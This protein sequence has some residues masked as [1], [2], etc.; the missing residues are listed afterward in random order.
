MFNLLANDQPFALYQG[1]LRNR[2]H[3]WADVL[4]LAEQ[5]PNRSYVFNFCENRYLFCVC[6]LAALLRKQT[7]LLPPN[8]QTA[9]IDE[10]RQ[11]YPD[12]YLACDDEQLFLNQPDC[13][14][15]KP[16]NTVSDALMPQWNWEDCAVIAFTSGSGG[17]AKPCQHQ[18]KT[19]AISAQLA[20]QSLSLNNQPRLMV[21]TTP[22]QHMYGL[23]TSVFWP[24][25]S[26]LILYDGHP[27]F[28]EDVRQSI[29]NAPYPAILSTTPAHLRSLISTQAKWSN[30]AAIIS[31]TDTLSEQLA[32]QT[33]NTLGML[34]YEIYGSTETLSFAYRHR[35]QHNNWQLYKNCQLHATPNDQTV[36]Q[37]AHLPE[38]YVLQDRIQ[39]LANQQF[40]LLG[41][42]E[43]MIK[44]AGKRISLSE[45]NQR[46]QN[47]TGVEDGVF[48][49]Q[50]NGENNVRLSA[51]V[52]SSLNKQAIRDS[53]RLYLDSVFLPRKI[54]FVPSM[55]R[56]KTGKLTKAALDNLIEHLNLL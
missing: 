13:F 26:S 51:I 39:L 56:N 9:V 6:L 15:V 1:R 22:P 37:A 46:L 30:L 35:G 7:C 18:L 53:L 55:P 11:H 49:L 31:A 14:I 42:D 2:G 52:V 54:Y 4:T 44:I 28:P 17:R 40:A 36:L 29:A 23:E 38:A 24:L 50:D 12:S 20:T 21:S 19:F 47:I 41:R 5:L 43:D 34:P 25:F 48:F 10:L 16:F 32:Q 33:A 3:L 45:L 8:Q 27:F